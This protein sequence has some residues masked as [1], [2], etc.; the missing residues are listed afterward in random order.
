MKEF[1]ERAFALL[2]FLIALR[3]EDRENFRAF[4]HRFGPIPPFGCRFFFLKYDFR[5]TFG[6]LLRSFVDWY[7][8]PL[9]HINISNPRRNESRESR[10]R[11]FIA[12]KQRVDEQGRRTFDF[13]RENFERFSRE[14]RRGNSR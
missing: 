11:F 6:H 4:S 14:S 7:A 1:N 2:F 10:V 12:A 9:F 13:F 5:Y 3:N 8:V